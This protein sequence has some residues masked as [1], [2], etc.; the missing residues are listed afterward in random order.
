MKSPQTF[1]EQTECIVNTLLMD[2]LGPTLRV[3]NRNLCC[4]DEVDSG[5][6]YTPE[7]SGISQQDLVCSRFQ[8]SL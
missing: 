5:R 8:L 6:S 2:F 3:A 1:E 7:H 4:V